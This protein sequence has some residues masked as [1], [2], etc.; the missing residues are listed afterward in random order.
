MQLLKITYETGATSPAVNDLI[1]FTD[2][3]KELAE[4]RDEIYQLWIDKKY[5][6][7]AWAFVELLKTAIRLYVK[8]IGEE[9]SIDIKYMGN[10]ERLQY[11]TIYAKRFENWKQEHNIK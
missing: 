3:T 2:T 6:M 11:R 4:L 8:E 7:D 1:L 5:L 10:K 9:D